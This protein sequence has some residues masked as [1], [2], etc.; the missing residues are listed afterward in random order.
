MSPGA[1]SAISAAPLPAQ[2]GLVDGVD[3]PMVA[4]AE[5]RWEKGALRLRLHPQR[6]E[7]EG[8][9]TQFRVVGLEDVSRWRLEGDGRCNA[10][11]T[12]LIIETTVR[13]H[14]LVLVPF[15]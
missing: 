5:A 7:A 6:A 15:G 12:E 8:T 14:R 9:P 1:W 10:N 3:F 13:D 4:L 2:P 11:G